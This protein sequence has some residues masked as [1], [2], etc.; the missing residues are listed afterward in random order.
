MK[1]HSIDSC[2]GSFPCISEA[3]VR[4]SAVVG[5]SFGITT[6]RSCMKLGIY[7]VNMNVLF[8]SPYSKYLT[9]TYLHCGYNTYSTLPTSTYLTRKCVPRALTQ[10]TSL[11][12]TRA[13]GKRSSRPTPTPPLT[14]TPTP[15]PTPMPT[16]HQHHASAAP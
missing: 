2:E 8:T 4:S 5:Q 1:V 11:H 3:L 12:C 10:S 14:P 6:G 9:V 16:P 13:P 7:E 15:T